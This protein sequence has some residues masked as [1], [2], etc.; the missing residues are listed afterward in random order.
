MCS[1]YMYGWLNLFTLYWILDQGIVGLWS[2]FERFLQV[3]V[4]EERIKN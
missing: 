4:T 3:D 1:N 2:F